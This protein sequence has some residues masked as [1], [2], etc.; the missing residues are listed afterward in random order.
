MVARRRN[1]SSLTMQVLLSVAWTGAGALAETGG[2]LAGARRMQEL[3]RGT[4]MLLVLVWLFG[5]VVWMCG[6]I[7]I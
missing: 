1:S 4:G 7:I 2:A 3:L 6:A 5:F